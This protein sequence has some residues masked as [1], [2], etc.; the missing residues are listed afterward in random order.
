MVEMAFR[1]EDEYKKFMKGCPKGKAK[2]SFASRFSFFGASSSS[3]A[4]SSGKKRK[5]M[6]GG[7]IN[8]R[9]S[10]A[11]RS[12]TGSGQVGSSSSIWQEGLVSSVVRWV[13]L[14]QIAPICN[15]H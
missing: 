13:I 1:F 10:F 11:G 2:T 9:H 8:G 4:G 15:K 12:D 14:L 6:S 5:E 3:G 7:A